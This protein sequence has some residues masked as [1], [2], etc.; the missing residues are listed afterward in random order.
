MIQ[1]KW[2]E[3]Y[4][5]HENYPDPCYTLDK[6][7]NK[8]FLGRIKLEEYG[9]LHYNL[10]LYYTIDTYSSHELG[11]KFK[12]LELAQI[13]AQEIVNNK[14]LLDCAFKRYE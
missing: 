4:M 3:H 7:D 12:T 9:G 11:G 1:L 2:S 13:A 14:V 6:Y 10:S 5:E 8:P